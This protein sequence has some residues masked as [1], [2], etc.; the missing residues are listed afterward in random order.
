MWR[1]ILITLFLTAGIAAAQSTSLWQ[2]VQMSDASP[3]NLYTNQQLIATGITNIF[4]PAFGSFN[5]NADPFKLASSST[6]TN[7]TVTSGSVTNTWAEDGVYY[8]VQETGVFEI[9][10]AISN[11]PSSQPFEVKFHGR[12]GG[13]PSHNVL[14]QAYDYVDGAYENI[15]NGTDDV[16]S[17]A[18]DGTYRWYFGAQAT[19]YIST[20]GWVSFRFLHDGSAVSSHYMYM[21]YLTVFFTDVV[22]PDAGTWYSFSGVNVDASNNMTLYPATA[23]IETIDAGT[24]RTAWYMSFVGSSNTT[25]AVRAVTN[26][27]PTDIVMYRTIGANSQIGSA[28]AF[29]YNYLGAGITNGWQIQADTDNA[30]V[31]IINGHAEVRKVSK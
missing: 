1:K 24:Y 6:V 5:V 30:G 14:A 18:A 28:S 26:G 12:Y 2:I 21:D 22:L 16:P 20:N 31:T 23:E 27:S 13:N 8:V 9:Y 11:A 7:G 3:D 15:G 4:K 25:F 17:G 10:F 19:N 29:G